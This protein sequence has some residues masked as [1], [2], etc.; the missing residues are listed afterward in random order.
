M[1]TE[2]VEVGRVWPLIGVESSLPTFFSFCQG[3]IRV[4]LNVNTIAQQPLVLQGS[5]KVF[6]LLKMS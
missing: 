2:L 1:M 6:V 3:R 5:I 4:V